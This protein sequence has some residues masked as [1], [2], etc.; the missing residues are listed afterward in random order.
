[1]STS[2]RQRATQITQ[3]TP[4]IR[5][6]GSTRGVIAA[7]VLLAAHHAT[8]AVELLVPAYFYPSPDPALSFWDELT[9]A[10]AAGAQITAII[11]PANGVG[12]AQNADYVNAIS[13]FK[14]AGGKV[15][16]YAY[17]CYGGTRCTPG[18]PAA[19]S[20][21]DV[22]TEAAQ[23]ASWY[24]VDGL[25]LDEMSNQASDLPYYTDLAATLRAQHPGWQLVGNP[26]TATPAAYLNVADTLVT[27]E[28]GTGSYLG[29]ATE[30]WMTTAD[31]S[32]QAHLHYNVADAS[33]MRTLV[34]EA[35]ARRAGYL[36]ITDDGAPNPWDRL[37]T[38]WNEELAAVN[39]ANAVSA[40]PEPASVVLMLVGL[41]TLGWR[42][43]ARRSCGNA[44]SAA[45]PAGCIG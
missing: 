15:L 2:T 1:M 5:T 34:S 14:D 28:R 17:T 6:F 16:G 7:V 35:V 27:F 39:A 20:V 31:P 22:V 9:A 21:A 30:P 12:A 36:Y 26:G 19:K 11:N 37:P 13:S 43:K 4:S 25:F 23:Y 3:A 44:P 45:R 41:A 38:Y 32:R 18:L 24:R 33:Q 8:Q 29:A 40:V 10:S 42:A